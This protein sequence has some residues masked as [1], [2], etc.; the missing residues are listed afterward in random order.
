MIVNRISPQIYP[1][2]FP[3]NKTKNPPFKKSSKY[4]KK[5]ITSL[6]DEIKPHIV[7][8]ATEVFMFILNVTYGL[9]YITIVSKIFYSIIFI[10]SLLSNLAH[11]GF[12]LFLR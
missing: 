5:F 8:Y 3:S 12:Q 1:E 7:Y 9:F 6:K 10:S 11:L 2:S 4:H